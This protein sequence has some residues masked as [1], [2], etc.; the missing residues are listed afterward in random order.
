MGRKPWTLAEG[1]RDVL[2]FLAR[3][4]PWAV[5]LWSGLAL[6]LSLWVRGGLGVSELSWF[7]IMIALISLAAGVPVGAVLSRGLNRA[8]AFAGWI[9]TLLAGAAAILAIGLGTVVTHVILPV[10]RPFY[11]AVIPAFAAVGAWAAVA[12]YT[13]AEA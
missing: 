10:E 5:A 6:I 1:V 11:L 8:V 7:T 9:P 3:R 4:G 2:A 12:K 13:W